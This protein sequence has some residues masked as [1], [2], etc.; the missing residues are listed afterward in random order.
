MRYN[1]FIIAIYGVSFSLGCAGPSSNSPK[2]SSYYGKD[3]HVLSIDGGGIRGIVPAYLLSQIEEATGK[4]VSEIFQSAGGTSTGGIL[5]IGLTT[6]GS[7]GKA[8]YSAAQMVSFY[9]QQGPEIFFNQPGVNWSVQTGYTKFGWQS[10]ENALQG[11]LGNTLLSQAVIPILITTWTP[12]LFN[13]TL[14]SSMP[15]AG[16]ITVEQPTGS[17]ALPTSKLKEYNLGCPAAQIAHATASA[18]GYFSPT[19]LSCKEPYPPLIANLLLRVSQM[20]AN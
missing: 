15:V 3:V 5:A 11:I 2:P 16:E 18:P 10:L 14:W 7:N 1:I 20:V 8:K 13:G 19:V 17:L 9:E 4:Q 6:P 12:E